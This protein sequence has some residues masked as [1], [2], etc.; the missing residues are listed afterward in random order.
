MKNSYALNLG[1]VLSAASVILFLLAAILDTGMVAGIAIMV[2]SLAVT[3]AACIIYLKKQRTA[4]G[5]LLS[6]KEGFV[7]SFLGMLIAG[8]VM[9]V[10]T[11]IYANFL[12]SSYIDNTVEKA[13]SGSLKFMEGNV[14]EDQLE[15]IM[16]GIEEDT[17]AGFTLMGVLKSL[18]SYAIFYAVLALIFGASLKKSEESLGQ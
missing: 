11:Y 2:V 18:V 16:V 17:R 1:M 13:L 15:E 14:P 4:Q 10:F 6:F 8:V 7:T 3:V 5:G 9:V 12:D